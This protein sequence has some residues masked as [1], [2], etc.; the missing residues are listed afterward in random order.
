MENF[1]EKQTS[2]Y[3]FMGASQNKNISALFSW[4]KFLNIRLALS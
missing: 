4:G 1:G 2:I 3:V